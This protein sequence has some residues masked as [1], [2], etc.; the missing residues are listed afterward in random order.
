MTFEHS[1]VLAVKCCRI[2]R[3][4]TY[5][6]LR[7]SLCLTIFFHRDPH[8]W[9]SLRRGSFRVCACGETSTHSLVPGSCT[10]WW[11]GRP[12]SPRIRGRFA[13]TSANFCSRSAILV[14]SATPRSWSLLGRPNYPSCPVRPT[15]VSGE[16]G[17]RVELA[18]TLTAPGLVVLNQFYDPRWV[19]DIRSDA[20]TAYRTRTVRTN[21]IMQGVFLRAGTHCLVFRYVPLDLYGAGA[22][23]LI[24]WLVVLVGLGGAAW[25]RRRRAGQI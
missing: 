5:S 9:K 2:R 25:K 24:S 19:V 21:R 8:G 16:G 12:G 3:Y 22:V 1:S 13:N 4:S 17:N 10:T 18:V 14:I 6:E 20:V 23:S 11:R 7:I 15:Q